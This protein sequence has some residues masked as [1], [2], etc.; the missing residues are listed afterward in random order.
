MPCDVMFVD[1]IIGDYG[2][3]EFKDWTVVLPRPKVFI[4]Y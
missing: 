3:T 4:E 1:L 2:S